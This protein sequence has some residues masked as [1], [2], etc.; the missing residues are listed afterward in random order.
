[1]A[2]RHLAKFRGRRSGGQ[3]AVIDSQLHEPPV[4]LSWEEPE[5]KIR[6]DVLVELE[7]LLIDAVGVDRAV[8]FPSES[9]LGEV[10][11]QPIP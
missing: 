2:G 11:G 5:E 10:R 6:W 3:I 4:S 1:M 7:L 8:L 9:R